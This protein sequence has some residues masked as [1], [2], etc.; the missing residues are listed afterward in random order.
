MVGISKCGYEMRKEAEATK[1]VNLGKKILGKII[2]ARKNRRYV[3]AV[4]HDIELPLDVTTRVRVFCNCQELNARTNLDDPTYATS[5]SFFGGEHGSHSGRTIERGRG[6]AS[7]C[8]DLT[9]ALA[10]LDPPR[11]RA[12]RI[13]VQLLP[14]C[15]NSEVN[16]SNVRPRRVEIVII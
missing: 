11:L 4:V 1:A 9:P 8:V 14:Q 13:T 15:L 2:D 7:V 3:W 6:S 5:L 12:D 16:V 10:R